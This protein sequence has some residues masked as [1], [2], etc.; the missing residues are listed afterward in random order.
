MALDDTTSTKQ[1][2]PQYLTG[3]SAFLSKSVKSKLEWLWKTYH[4]RLGFHVN[5][6]TTFCGN[7][8]GENLFTCFMF[9][10]YFLIYSALVSSDH[11]LRYLSAPSSLAILR[12][13]KEV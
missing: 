5:A 12:R 9:F 3:N 4:S 2:K 8:G 6:L 13:E 11:L 7:L 10:F 1:L